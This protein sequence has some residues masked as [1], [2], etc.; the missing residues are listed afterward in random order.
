MPLHELPVKFT[1]I[2]GSHERRRC[3]HVLDLRGDSAEFDIFNERNDACMLAD[4]ILGRVS[5]WSAAKLRWYSQD[6]E[7]LLGHEW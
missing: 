6:H 1:A 3:K 2:F 7:F 5:S 4:H